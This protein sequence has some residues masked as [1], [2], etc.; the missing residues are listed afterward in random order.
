MTQYDVAVVGGG[1]A[2]SATA[3]RLVE[4]GL[5]VALLDRAQFPRPKPCAEY[6]SPGTVAA[7]GRLGVLDHVQALGPV[8]LRGMRIVG[9]DGTSFE[10]HFLEG[11]GLSVS[12]ERLDA[13]LVGAARQR[14]VV[15]WEETT[16]TGLAGASHGTVH[17][18]ARCHGEPLALAARLVIGADG[19]NSRVARSLGLARPPAGRRVALV[20]H[21]T[22]VTGM[23][24]VGE[25]HVGPAGYVGIAPLDGGSTTV[26][27]VVDREALPAHRSLADAL[28]ALLAGFPVLRH[29]VAGAEFVSP[30][31]GVGPFGRTTRRASTDHALLVGDAADFFDPFTGEGVYAALAGAELATEFA[32]RAL[33]RNRLAA[34][35]LAPYQRA[36]R[37]AFA[38]KWTLERIVAW[39][40]ARP[41]ALAHVAKRLARQP[42]LADRLVSVTA[43]VTPAAAVFRPSYVYHLV[44]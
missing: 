28:R 1:P 3:A 17:L 9:G 23:S 41:A 42:G 38:T 25:M 18:F 21:A 13:I 16:V 32:A 14:G 40:I 37:Q 43:H 44:A 31:R 33:A 27:A 11:V 8:R 15:L 39:V 30:V 22:G 7:L 19:L 6:L 20:A 5:S 34:H 4:R 35:D 26:A 10:G 29:R 36:R 12:R 2:G 24:D